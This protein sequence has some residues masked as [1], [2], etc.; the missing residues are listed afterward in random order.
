[1]FCEYVKN[2]S[3][4]FQNVGA[5]ASSVEG[6]SNVGAIGLVADAGYRLKEL[7]GHPWQ[8]QYAPSLYNFMNKHISTYPEW[9]FNEYRPI[10][11]FGI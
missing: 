6:G 9:I 11:Q 8:D 5:V 4:T 3:V 7:A 10:N 2:H 1:V